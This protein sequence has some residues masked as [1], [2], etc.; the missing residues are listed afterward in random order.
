MCDVYPEEVQEGMIFLQPYED[1]PTKR[2]KANDEF[3]L[4]RY[5]LVEST[6]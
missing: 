1:V 3:V 5:S 2:R 6:E 4:Q